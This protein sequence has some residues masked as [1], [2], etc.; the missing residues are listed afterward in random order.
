MACQWLRANDKK[1][2]ES[3]SPPSRKNAKGDW[4]AKDEITLEKSKKAVAYLRDLPG[5]PVW[6]NRRSV[7]RFGGITNIYYDLASGRIPKTQAFLDEALESND[8]WCKRKIQW[9]IGEMIR[10]GKPLHFPQIQIKTAVS[11]ETIER[12]ADFTHECIMRQMK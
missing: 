5:R 12:L 10:E 6:V 2:Y 4:A 7:E 3:N 9:A 1:W 11:P 8:D